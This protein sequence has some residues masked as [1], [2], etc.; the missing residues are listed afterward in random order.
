M[1]S[2]KSDAWKNFIGKSTDLKFIPKDPY[3]HA[4]H[5]ISVEDKDVGTFQQLLNKHVLLGNVDSDELMRFYQ[6]DV[7]FLT[8]F[9]QM[10]GR[11]EGLKNFFQIQYSAW[12]HEIAL[13]RA[14]GGME[15]WLQ[16]LLQ[17]LPQ[18]IPGYGKS[19]EDNYRKQQQQQQNIQGAVLG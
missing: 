8:H 4:S 1:E 10:S 19:L 9:Y 7:Y 11:D 12:V 18:K 17:T 13:T 6:T 15:R 5:L 3:S 16:S 14:K 2:P